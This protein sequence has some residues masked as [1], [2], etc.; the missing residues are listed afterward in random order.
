MTLILLQTKCLRL[1]VSLRR[2]TQALYYV[3]LQ[4][5]SITIKS[6]FFMFHSYSA[7]LVSYKI[8]TLSDDLKLFCIDWL[9]LR[10]KQLC[11]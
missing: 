9:E 10:D 7:T 4:L 2:E 3:F 8:K 11:L 5:H 6:Q 1:A